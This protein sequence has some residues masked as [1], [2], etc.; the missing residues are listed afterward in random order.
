MVL[1]QGILLRLWDT[2]LILRRIVLVLALAFAT[3][4][5]PVHPAHADTALSYQEAY[6]QLCRPEFLWNCE[7]FVSTAYRESRFTPSA[8]NPDCDNSGTYTHR[9]IGFL[10]LWEAHAP[11]GDPNELFDLEINIQTAYR[12]WLRDGYR[13]WGG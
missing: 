12:L 8:Y 1:E 10:Q 13:P 11:N 6:E 7:Y 2:N 9:C 5:L 4:F 3:T